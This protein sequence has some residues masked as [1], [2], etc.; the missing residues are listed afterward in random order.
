MIRDSFHEKH[1]RLVEGLHP[2]GRDSL[3]NGIIDLVGL[4]LF[5]DALPHPGGGDQNLHR[6][7]PSHPIRPR[8]QPL[9]DDP[10]EHSRQLQA[11]LFLMVRGK[12]GD[13]TGDRLR[14]IQGVEGGHDQMAGL[15]C[16]QGGLDRLEVPHLAHQDHIRILPEGHPQGAGKGA[17][18]R[19]N[20]PLVDDRFLV[21]VDEFDGILDGDDVTVPV[22]C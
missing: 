14:G 1:E 9:G 2:V 17:R 8:H 3:G 13:D 12:D 21:L 10:F 11:N 22:H 18:I 16:G 20:L 5:D 19:A 6:R 4:I 15:G 7:N